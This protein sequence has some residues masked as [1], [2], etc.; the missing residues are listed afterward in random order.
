MGSSD[1]DYI[2]I[3]IVCELV[4]GTVCFC[5]RGGANV[6]EEGFGAG[7]GGGGCC[8]CDG[9]VD[10]GYVA[11]EGVG[12]EVF[13]EGWMGFRLVLEDQLKIE[14]WYG[15]DLLLFLRWREY[16]T[17]LSMVLLPLC[18]NYQTFDRKMCL[19]AGS[20]NKL[21]VLELSRVLGRGW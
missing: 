17:L 21:M 9:V 2:D 16:P 20:E 19:S 13:C 1:V 6:A 8:C 14:G 4:V 3:G 7:F 10:V 15:T 18:R 5:G 12:E 11:G